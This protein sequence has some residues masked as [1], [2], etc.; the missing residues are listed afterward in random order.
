MNL[1]NKET[2][3]QKIYIKLIGSTTFFQGWETERI[4]EQCDYLSRVASIAVDSYVEEQEEINYF[5][6]NE[7]TYCK[8]QLKD[9]KIDPPTNVPESIEELMHYA[10][11]Y[12]SN[13]YIYGPCT[14]SQALRYE[15]K[16]TRPVYIRDLKTNKIE[17][18]FNILFNKFVP[19]QTD[20]NPTS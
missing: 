14:L 16:D 9:V 1:K 8:D 19:H 15:V 17:Y 10:V 13:E 3:R 5:E 20:E 4:Q 11:G 2:L 6:G 12:Y 7:P 18:A